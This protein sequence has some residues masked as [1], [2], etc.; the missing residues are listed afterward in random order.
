MFKPAV[1]QPGMCVPLGVHVKLTGGTQN[2][3]NHSKEAHL[4][5][6]FDLGVRE[7]H[8]ILIWG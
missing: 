2:V 3:K 7:G 1:F 4:G 6:N 8:T 5:R